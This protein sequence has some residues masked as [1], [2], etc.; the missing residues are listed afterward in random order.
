MLSA[1]DYAR[2]RAFTTTGTI[3]ADGERGRELF[4]FPA[5]EVDAARDAEA[6]VHGVETLRE[7]I[8]VLSAA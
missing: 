2:G 7:A 1:Q 6:P 5:N 8:E 3:D 4:L